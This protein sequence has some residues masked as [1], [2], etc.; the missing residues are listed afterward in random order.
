MFVLIRNDKIIKTMANLETSKLKENQ[1][2]SFMLIDGVFQ[3]NDAANVLIS[4]ISNKIKFHNILVLSAYECIGGAN[5]KS[6][7][8]IDELENAKNEINKLVKQVH[9]VGGQLKVRSEITIEIIEK[10]PF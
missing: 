2:K 7:K 3:P 10:Q 4:L 8:R 5:D 1:K 9:K 6:K